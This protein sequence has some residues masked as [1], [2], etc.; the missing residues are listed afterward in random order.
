MC[1]CGFWATAG[2]IRIFR[3]GGGPLPVSTCAHHCFAPSS[4]FIPYIYMCSP[5]STSIVLAP[6][7]PRRPSY[8][9][10]GSWMA[11]CPRTPF[12]S[13]GEGSV[14]GRSVFNP[15]FE[16]GKTTYRGVRWSGRSASGRVEPLCGPAFPGFLELHIRVACTRIWR[17]RLYASPRRGGGVRVETAGEGR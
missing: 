13:P 7:T 14:W 5:R 16:A 17:P 10:P 4:Q 9:Y 12:G 2:K 15:P 3:V 1:R 11:S 6:I 8:T